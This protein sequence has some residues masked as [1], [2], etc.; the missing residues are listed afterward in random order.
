LTAAGW[1]GKAETLIDRIDRINF[2]V[3][4]IVLYPVNS[5]NPVYFI[6]NK[7]APIAIATGHFLECGDSSPLWFEGKALT[8]RRTPN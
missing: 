6:L 3:R 2:K 5:V 7:D 1:A 4:I 8:S